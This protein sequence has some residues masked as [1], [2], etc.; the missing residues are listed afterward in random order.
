MSAVNEISF[1]GCSV[2][3][4]SVRVATEARVTRRRFAHL[5]IFPHR[6]ELL[7]AALLI[8]LSSPP[9][10]RTSSSLLGS[11][12]PRRCSGLVNRF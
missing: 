7:R 4:W 3:S 5:Y 9:S 8:Q 10:S 6:G 12:A 11:L 2:S 1:G